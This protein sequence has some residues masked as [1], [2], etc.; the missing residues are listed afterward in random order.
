MLS[1]EVILDG[2]FFVRLLAEAESFVEASLLTCRGAIALRAHVHEPT[3]ST[4]AARNF[5]EIHCP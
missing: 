3:S 2:H 1:S 4:T 5:N